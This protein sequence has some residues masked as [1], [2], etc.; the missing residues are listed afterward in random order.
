MEQAQ[1]FIDHVI[2]FSITTFSASIINWMPRQLLMLYLV[3]GAILNILNVLKCL[4]MI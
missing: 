3:V 4:N 2:Y 1:A